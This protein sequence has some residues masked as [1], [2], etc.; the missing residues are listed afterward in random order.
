MPLSTH[1][2][3]R[4]TIIT[5]DLRKICLTHH[6]QQRYYPAQHMHRVQPGDDIQELTAAGAPKSD[7]GGPDLAEPYPLQQHKD[8]AQYGR[9]RQQIA[10]SQH[11][12][13]F[14]GL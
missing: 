13:I 6:E 2:L 1:Q 8:D 14:K 5:P 7:P 4:Y 9:C 3:H 10:V 12:P 11:F